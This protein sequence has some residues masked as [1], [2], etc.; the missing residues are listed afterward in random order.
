MP[1]SR[2]G[3]PGWR[4]GSGFDSRPP[5]RGGGA[6]S[7]EV[8]AAASEVENSGSASETN[9]F[10]KGGHDADLLEATVALHLQDAGLLEN[11]DVFGGVVVGDPET[12]RDLA[13]MLGAGRGDEEPDDLPAALI[14]E[15]AEKGKAV[16]RVRSSHGFGEAYHKASWDAGEISARDTK[17]RC[18][19]TLSLYDDVQAMHYESA[20][21]TALWLVVFAFVSLSLVMSMSRRYRLM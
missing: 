21:H 9:P 20:A 4:S 1:P 19:L 8:E 5:I 14:R 7:L 6:G 2:N 13:E 12:L 18:F 15:G 16:C 11:A 17:P 10:Q 3:G